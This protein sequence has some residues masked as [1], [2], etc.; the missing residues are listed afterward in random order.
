MES[1]IERKETQN[2]MEF[3]TPR[4]KF[5]IYFWT[6]VELKVKLAELQDVVK[7]EQEFLDLMEGK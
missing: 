3:G 4:R 6:T 5:K 2:S 1:T 7:Q